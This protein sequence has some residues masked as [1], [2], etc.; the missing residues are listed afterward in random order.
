M[1]FE[2]KKKKIFKANAFMRIW[3]YLTVTLLFFYSL[4]I[5]FASS[6]HISNISTQLNNWLVYNKSYG[7]YTPV[8]INYI[9]NKKILHQKIEILEYATLKLQ[10][11]IPPEA[12]IFFNNKLVAR[13]TNQADNIYQFSI[14]SLLYI[15]QQ[16]LF[17]TVYAP[18]SNAHL[19][20][21]KIIDYA[22]TTV[23]KVENK[24][25][26]NDFFRPILR[27][28]H[29]DNAYVY[30][31]MI[32]ILLV[33]IIKNTDEDITADFF[34]FR[35]IL[36][37]NQLEDSQLFKL[38]NP[39]IIFILIIESL[40]I[41]YLIY[42]YRL[43]YQ[44]NT[45]KIIYFSD[46]AQKSLWVFA[47]F[48]A[49]YFLINLMAWIFKQNHLIKIHFFE[50]VK[51]LFKVLIVWSIIISAIQYGNFLNQNVKD[52]FF[53]ILLL[54]ALLLVYFKTFIITTKLSYSRN[55]YLFSYLCISELMP[56]VFFFKYLAN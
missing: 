42:Q 32:T 38:T 21:I 2:N 19:S 45:S 54:I 9:Y 35:N 17:F 48:L 22:L 15:D 12:S 1:I 14:D 3:P 7:I 25:E 49:K 39:S 31:F 47:F 27:K 43:F 34:G 51:I 55:I 4:S 53:T 52:Y 11:S 8:D 41:I 13:N 56:M 33:A 10:V 23:S 18:N 24:S 26:Q 16:N 5:V 46:L 28:F 36:S 20:K 44:L 29:S 40:V 6:Q 30:I 37:N 50:Q